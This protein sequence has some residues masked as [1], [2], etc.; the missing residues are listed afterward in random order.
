MKGAFIVIEGPDGVGKTR[1]ALAIAKWLRDL[2]YSV[3][4]TREPSDGS[5]GCRIRE[6]LRGEIPAKD[7]EGMSRLYAEDRLDHLARV[8][9]PALV[10]EE[11]VI[12]DRYLLS[13]IAYQHGAMGLA[14]SD[15]LGFNRYAINPD[16][17]LVLTASEDVCA[18]RRRER[19]DAQTM[20]EDDET[21]RKIRRIYGEAQS[22]VSHH[23]PISID[24]SGNFDEVLKA[25][26]QHVMR[27]IEEMSR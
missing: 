13:A 6:M 27:T 3:V 19:G 7:A 5:I 21:Q 18:A 15:V 1:M 14:L 8:V 17:T 4:H 24:A 9:L 16:L 22:F 12:C 20:F 26:M 23:N 11:I 10:G 25:C 2:R